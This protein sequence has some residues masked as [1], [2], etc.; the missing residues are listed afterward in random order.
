MAHWFNAQRRQ[1][2]CV[3]YFGQPRYQRH[4]EDPNQTKPKVD[5]TVTFCMACVLSLTFCPPPPPYTTSKRKYWLIRWRDHI[6]HVPCVK[7]LRCS[8]LRPSP[9]SFVHALAWEG[10]LSA[11]D[12]SGLWIFHVEWA[13]LFKSVQF[14]PS[15]ARA[16]EGA[17]EEKGETLKC[18]RWPGEVFGLKSFFH[19]AFVL[20]PVWGVRFCFFLIMLEHVAFH[21]CGIFPVFLF[22]SL[23]VSPL[24]PPPLFILVLLSSL[25]SILTAFRH[26]GGGSGGR[27]LNYGIWV[28]AC[29]D[30][31]VD[32]QK[33]C[34]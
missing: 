5:W 30:S 31:N 18:K 25:V 1:Q 7:A 10:R 16:L 24:L 27:R 21:W 17:R 15:W 22:S 3:L 20:F 33:I 34:F 11:F 19:P 23:L 29:L 8:L 6:S 32:D 4:I 14:T 2:Q 12:G 26:L 28:Y 9:V 13:D